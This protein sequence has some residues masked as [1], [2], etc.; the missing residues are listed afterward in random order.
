MTATK[1]LLVDDETAILSNL[2]EAMAMAQFDVLT[3]SDKRSALDAVATHKIDLALIDLRLPDGDGLELARSIRASAEIPILMMSGKA[4]DVDRILGLELVAD[5][6]LQKPFLHRELIARVR[7]ILRRYGQN[8]EKDKAGHLPS[9]SAEE[10]L[11]GL[12]LNR[13]ARRVMRPDGTD[14]DLTTRE[15]DVLCVLAEHRGTVLTRQDIYAA[16]GI[17]KGHVDRQVDGL[18][19]R[20]RTKLNGSG[21]DGLQIRTVHGRGYVLTELVP[22]QQHL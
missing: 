18:V 15:F 21:T 16:A 11:Q 6:Y 12:T 17:G 19:C 3:A 9:T 10:T 13:G 2:S 7:A 5:D 20:L 1:V 14:I 22:T 8:D 4:D